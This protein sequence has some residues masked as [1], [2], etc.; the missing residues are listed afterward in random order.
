[1]AR[2][3]ARKKARELSNDELQLI[4]GGVET[5]QTFEYTDCGQVGA[6]GNY[7]PFADDTVIVDWRA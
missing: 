6:D 4:S 1:M 2:V 3:M 5:W 7:Y